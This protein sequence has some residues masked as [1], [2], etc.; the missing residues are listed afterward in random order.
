MPKQ[1]Q[2]SQSDSKS[3]KSKPVVRQSGSKSF[4]PRVTESKLLST[5]AQRDTKSEKDQVEVKSESP[6][7]SPE[8]AVSVA[9][10]GDVR[11]G[12]KSI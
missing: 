7:G 12:L 11:S 5:R 1:Q 8:N 2:L 6:V 4:V 10:F 9:S 3:L